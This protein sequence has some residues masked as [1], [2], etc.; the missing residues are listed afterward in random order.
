MYQNGRKG[1]VDHYLFQCIHTL[2]AEELLLP[3]QHAQ[4]Q[5]EKYGKCRLDNGK[6]LIHDNYLITPF[7]RMMLA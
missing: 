6:Q 7:C 3:A 4:K 1:D 5:G 2:T